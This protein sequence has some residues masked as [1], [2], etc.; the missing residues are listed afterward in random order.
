[1]TK[2][3]SIPTENQEQR[4]LVKWL[5]FNPQ[6]KDFFCKNNNEG[7]RTAAQGHNLRL[8][9]LRAGVSDLTIY[10]PTKTH[11][12]LFLEVKR[13]MN[14]PPSARKSETWLAQEEFARIVKSV[15]YEAKTCYG[16]VD[17]KEIIEKYLL[18]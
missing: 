5:S 14:Y 2:R 9:G 1:M 16:W 18:S 15:G 11:H 8:M 12:G 4:W 3:V 17:G 6:L 10:Y 7:K 13:A